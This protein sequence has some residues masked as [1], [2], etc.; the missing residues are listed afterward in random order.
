MWDQNYKHGFGIFT[1]QDG[2]QYIGRFHNDKMIEYNI[3][4]FSIPNGVKPQ[5][6]RVST[7][8]SKQGNKLKNTGAISRIANQTSKL[9]EDQT[10]NESQ[11]LSEKEDSKQKA[12]TNLIHKNSL[13]NVN[14]INESLNSIT[15]ANGKINF[16]IFYL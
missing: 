9:R 3:Y 6:E 8:N 4:G 15:N 1:F 10:L 5:N 12:N 13:T 7:A 11:K 14:N 2:S 16:F